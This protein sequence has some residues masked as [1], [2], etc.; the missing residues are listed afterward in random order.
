MDTAGWVMGAKPSVEKGKLRQ[1]WGAHPSPTACVG[2][3]LSPL[4]AKGCVGVGAGWD[5]V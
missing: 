2:W 1:Q 5:Q 4:R 3:S